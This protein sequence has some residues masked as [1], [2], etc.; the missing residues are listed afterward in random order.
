MLVCKRKAAQQNCKA[1]KPP[2][3]RTQSGYKFKWAIT[4]K[5][6]FVLLNS[7][8]HLTIVDIAE[9]IIL[10]EPRLDLHRVFISIKAVIQAIRKKEK[11]IKDFSDLGTI[12]Y[13]LAHEI[14]QEIRIK[15]K[16]S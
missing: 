7:Y 11:Y 14:R 6:D 9:Q 4:Q 5:V 1:R 16:Y 2:T 3:K 10:L 15:L 13:H 8:N 12:K